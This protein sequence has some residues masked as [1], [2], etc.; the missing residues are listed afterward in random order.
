MVNSMGGRGSNGKSGGSGSSDKY[1]EENI[2]KRMNQIINASGN[3]ESY[4]RKVSLSDWEG[5]EK[6]RTYIKVYETRKNSKRNVSYDYGYV[7]RQTNKYVAG[8]HDMEKNYSL[9]GI[10][11]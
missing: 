9:G 8:K 1:S 11:F 4:I 10:K 7:D 6:K 5:Y 3:D 2:H